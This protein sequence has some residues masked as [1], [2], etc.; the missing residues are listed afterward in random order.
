MT[1]QR[2]LLI[3]GDVVSFTAAAAAQKIYE[4]RFGIVQPFAHRQEGE[5]IIDNMVAGF[6]KAFDTDKF[7]VY[8]TDPVN[9]WRTEVMPTYKHHRA[10]AFPGQSRPLLLSRMKA[11]MTENYGASFWPTLEADDVLGIM[12]TEPQDTEE[13]IIVGKDKDMKTLPGA[14]FKLK[15]YDYKG[16]PNI[17]V[18]TPWQATRFHMFQTLKGDMTDGYPGCPGMGDKRAE[19]LLEN[20][21]LL[22]PTHGVKTSGKNKGDPTTKWVSEPT[23]D[24][25]AMI[26]SHYEKGGLTEEDALANA[27]V[28]NILHHDQY[29]RATGDIT[30]WTPERLVGL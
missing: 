19:E 26:V 15:D 28:A 11:Y 4:D 8:L 5:A 16:R 20:P 29:D 27:R 21:V 6:L 18:S 7:H 23:R 10:E 25:W 2:V 9:N 3:D 1:K 30:L 14:Y 17:R 22:R 24:F 13:R 12:V